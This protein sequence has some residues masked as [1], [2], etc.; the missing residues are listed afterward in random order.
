MRILAIALVIISIVGCAATG[1]RKEAPP[2]AAESK[3]VGEGSLD[4]KE[5]VKTL[6]NEGLKL[7]NDTPQA[8]L[9]LFNEVARTSPNAW[10]ANYNIALI[11]LRL[12]DSKKAEVDLIKSLNKKAP[13]AKIYNALG[14]IHIYN[15]NKQKAIDIFEMSLMSE[16]TTMALVN[17]AG[18]Y[19][20]MGEAEKA[21]KY[22]SEAETSDPASR[23]VYT[24]LLSYG[25]GR[26][27]S[28]QEAFKKALDNGNR[29]ARIMYLYV[30]T[31]L[32]QGDYNA[33]LKVLQEIYT[34]IPADPNPYRD[35]G[36]IYEVYLGDLNKA[37]KNYGL[38]IGYGGEKE[39]EVREWINVINMRLS[40]ESKKDDR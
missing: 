18:L 14:L 15:G 7:M 23:T 32:K 35:M 5:K 16:K 19:I 21:A 30:Q 34:A 40:Q 25:T 1:E 9:N 28:A 24:A 39:K 29:D 17:L 4:G 27:Q 12:G 38:Y 8:A 3:G 36:I 37:A 13:P 33:A 20:S 6:F 2:M 31:L 22:Y 11:H 10:E 26:Y